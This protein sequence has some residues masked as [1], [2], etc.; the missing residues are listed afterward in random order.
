M[1]LIHQTLLTSCILILHQSATTFIVAQSLLEGVAQTQKLFCSL[2][3]ETSKSFFSAF[4]SLSNSF[5]NQTSSNCL[6]QRISSLS[7]VI[8]IDNTT[9]GSLQE[10]T[11]QKIKSALTSRHY[12]QAC[13]EW[14]GQSPR[15]NARAT[16]LRRN[17]AAVASRCR[18]CVR[19]DRPENG[20][21]DRPRR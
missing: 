15:L 19:F 6:I 11:N 12:P 8:N 9:S 14:R 18:H 4:D 1:V 21:H 3:I 17:V 7:A 16:Q 5:F 2:I 13:N 20:T 10:K